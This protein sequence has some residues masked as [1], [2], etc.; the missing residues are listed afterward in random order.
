MIH[1]KLSSGLICIIDDE[2]YSIFASYKWHSFKKHNTFYV[3][4][5]VGYYPNRYPILLHR[6]IMNAPK[7]MQI[8]HINKNGLDNRKCNLR[9]VT[10]SENCKNRDFNNINNIKKNAKG[11][12]VKKEKNINN[13]INLF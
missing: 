1:C 12:F 7:Y 13:Q 2:D 6:L 11:Q 10:A 9:I 5:N 3:R 8:D 4:T